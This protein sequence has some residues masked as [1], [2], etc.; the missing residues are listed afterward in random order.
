MDNP[1]ENKQFVGAGIKISMYQRWRLVPRRG[2]VS[3]GVNGEVAPME[4]FSKW[5][6]RKY[7]AMMRA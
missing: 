1:Q 3:W 7:D 6:R 5:V 4:P 2:N